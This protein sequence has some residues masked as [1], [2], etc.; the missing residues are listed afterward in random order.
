MEI[1]ITI[2]ASVASTLIVAGLTS[3]L[4]YFKGQAKTYK[5]L[6][7]QQKSDSVRNTVREEIEPVIEEIHRLQKRIENHEMRESQDVDIILNSWKFRLIQLCSTYIRQGFMTQAQY[8]QLSE[9]YKAYHDLGGNG[10]AQ[11]YYERVKTLPIRDVPA[12]HA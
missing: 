7:E 6:L 11:E 1:L 9:F 2:I 12:N 8:D 3:L 5:K 10:Q 4:L